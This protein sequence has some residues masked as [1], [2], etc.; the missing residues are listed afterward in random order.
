MSNDKA[1]S[2]AKYHDEHAGYGGVS[3]EFHARAATF[4]RDIAAAKDEAIAR[5]EKAERS[6]R[7]M[8]LLESAPE[9]VVLNGPVDSVCEKWSIEW[10]TGH[11]CHGFPIRAIEHGDTAVAAILDALDKETK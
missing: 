7:A 1:E 10:T 3:W 9:Y 2:F 4:I 11:D 6:H 5:A 8:T